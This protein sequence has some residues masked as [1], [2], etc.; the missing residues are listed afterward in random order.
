MSLH[1]LNKV[2]QD[3]LQDLFSACTLSLNATTD[4]SH[5]AS[6][7]ELRTVLILGA[8][9]L[10]ESMEKLKAVC[11]KY[12]IDADGADCRGM[13]ALVKEVHAQVLDAEFSEST[14]RDT[15]IIT[16]YQRM[17]HYTLAGFGCIVA[18]AN[19]LE[20]EEDACLLKTQMT[21]IHEGSR[22]ITEIAGNY[23][24]QKAA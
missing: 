23:L 6:H 19:R 3:Q 10:F 9:G 4:L 5:A 22:R 8:K 13:R 11:A 17:V 15:M 1:N 7:K 18:F 16:Q 24:N 20:L 2:Y 12:N 21:A 14:T